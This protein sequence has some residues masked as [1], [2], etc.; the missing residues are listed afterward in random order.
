MP[1]LEARF[2][3]K[4]KDGDAVVVVGRVRCE[5]RHAVIEPLASGEMFEK[6]CYLV[7]QSEPE[8]YERLRSLRSEFWSFVEIQGRSS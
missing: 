8:P 7:R 1:L 2:H 4:K 6:L 3:P 5:G